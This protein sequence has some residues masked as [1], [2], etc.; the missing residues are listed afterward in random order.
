MVCRDFSHG[1][2]W[3]VGKHIINDNGSKWADDVW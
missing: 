3:A 1:S 2:N